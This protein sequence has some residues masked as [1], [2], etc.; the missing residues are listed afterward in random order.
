MENAFLVGTK[1]V[2]GDV[3]KCEINF[4][5][6]SFSTHSCIILHTSTTTSEAHGYQ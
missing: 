2:L 3:Q 4:Q 1:I 6:S 5:E